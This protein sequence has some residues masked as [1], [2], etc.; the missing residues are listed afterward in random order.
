[1]TVVIDSGIWVSA[2][3]YGGPPFAALERALH[4]GRLATCDEIEA[5]V[6]RILFRK[7]GRSS[8][9]T[10]RRLQL[11][12]AEAIRIEVT[13]EVRGVCRDPNDECVLEC[14]LKSSAQFI[15][16]GDNDLLVLGKFRGTRIITARQYLD[17]PG[18]E[19]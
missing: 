9:A 17:L 3:E 7:F 15:V 1:M 6:I 10:R 14:A 2:F 18:E 12:L 11:S 16:T 8:E 13:G 19:V 4:A 5:E